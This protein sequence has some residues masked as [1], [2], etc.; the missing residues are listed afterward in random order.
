MATEPA[1]A[2][3]LTREYPQLIDDD[4]ARLLAANSSEACTYLWR[5]HTQGKLQ[6]DLQPIN[7]MLGYHTPCHLRALQVGTPG[8]HLLG[9]I[10]GVRIE[11]LEKGCSGMAG[12]FGLFEKNYRGSLCGNSVDQPI[13]QSRLASRRDRM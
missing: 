2:L 4:D 9:L 10:P 5:M 8:E 1:A 11:H 12:T 6:M 7:V 13:A 3:C